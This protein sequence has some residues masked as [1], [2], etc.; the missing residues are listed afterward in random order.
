MICGVNSGEHSEQIFQIFSDQILHYA[1]LMC[2]VKFGS[3]DCLPSAVYIDTCEDCVD[4][5]FQL[6]QAGV[7]TAIANRQWSIKVMNKF[8]LGG[9]IRKAL[10][11]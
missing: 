10:L 11:S 3:L 6:G 8:I 7:G 1:T 9:E 2:N 5:S 4:L